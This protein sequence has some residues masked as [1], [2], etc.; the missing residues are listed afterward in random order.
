MGWLSLLLDWRAW[1]AA[2]IAGLALTNC[3]THQRLEREQVAHKAS[4]EAFAETVRLANAAHAAAETRNRTLE[5]DLIDVNAKKAQAVQAV[6]N[7]AAADA[8]RDAADSDRL[9]DEAAIY[10]QR[11]REACAAPSVV[12]PGPA[13]KNDPI[14]VLAHVLSRADARASELAAIADD[15][16]IRGLA[17]ESEYN[18]AREAVAAS[19]GPP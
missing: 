2:L 10:A 15:A 18:A 8:R 9:R 4:R 3:I 1:L 12:A 19:A 13:V 5:K 7:A 14:G 11:A 17:C 6:L 16:R